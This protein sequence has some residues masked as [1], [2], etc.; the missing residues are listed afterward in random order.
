MVSQG[1]RKALEV[2]GHG[3]YGA[4]YPV[5]YIQRLDGPVCVGEW[6]GIG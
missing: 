2:W 5:I 6:Y 3:G 4:G 1:C